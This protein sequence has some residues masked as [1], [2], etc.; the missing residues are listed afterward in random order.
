MLTQ[1]NL[2]VRYSVRGEVLAPRWESRGS[3]EC[4][5]SPGSAWSDVVLVEQY[6]RRWV[7]SAVWPDGHGQK[8][9]S[10]CCSAYALSIAEARGKGVLS[11]DMG[12]GGR[13]LG[14]EPWRRRGGP[15]GVL[16]RLF[17]A[18]VRD[19]PPLWGVGGF[20]GG[21]HLS[22]RGLVPPRVS[23]MGWRSA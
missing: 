8:Q 18:G 17:G 4:H 22:W 12:I 14:L 16:G 23:Y 2:L 11:R 21:W 6:V 3:L 19:P 5:S 10:V 9:L 15:R 7:S 1:T 20:G 13:G